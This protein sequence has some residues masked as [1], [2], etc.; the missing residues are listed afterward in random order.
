MF[1]TLTIVWA[2]ITAPLRL[3]SA[4]GPPAPV[5][6]PAGPAPATAPAAAAGA[7]AAPPVTAKPPEPPR[8]K[9]PDEGKIQSPDGKTHYFYRTNF[10]KAQDLVATVNT[11]LKM[12]SVTLTAVERPAPAPPAAQIRGGN[13]VI[14]EGTEEDIQMALDVIAYFDVPDPQVYVEAKIIEITYDNNFEIGLSSLMDRDKAGPNTF[15]RGE[16]VTLNPPSFFQSQL[17]GNLP[18]Q[19]A[20]LAF[21]LAGKAA[22]KYGALDITLQALQRNGT[23]E[24]LSRPSIVATEGVE[25]FVQTEQKTPVISLD[26]AS[27]TTPIPGA[28]GFGPYST[29]LNLR[30]NYVS[31]KIGLK[32]TPLFIG[33]GF[34]K[35]HVLP[36]V[37]TITGFSVGQG[38]TSAPIISDRS[39]D[40]VITMADGE[41][42]VIGGLYT[43]LSL[44]DTAKIPFLGD[45]P[46]V[47]ALFTRTR[48]TK[49]KTELVFHIT[50]HIL[51]KKTDYKIIAPPSEK[52]RLEGA[53]PAGDEPVPGSR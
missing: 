36:T 49:V 2:G 28:Q 42:L 46:C 24:I 48:D 27:S 32:V 26:S 45:I 14:L 34:V 31:S 29:T 11:L 7:P 16:A 43:D 30:T 51:R 18:F 39:A 6:P 41:T 5:A 33:D 4:D 15:Y 23:A 52:E 8:M 37:S 35:L 22:E 20:G 50:P 13:Q 3:T 53:C 21:G 40:T 44:K 10:V 17:P 1:I 47:G 12:P 25:S 9:F 38:G 19:G